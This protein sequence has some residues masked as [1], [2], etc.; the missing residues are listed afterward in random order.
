MIPDEELIEFI[1]I[2]RTRHKDYYDRIERRSDVSLANAPTAKNSIG[3]NI[4]ASDVGY[5]ST[6]QIG[7]PPRNFSVIM[8]SGSSDLWVGGEGCHTEVNGT[9]TGKNCGDK[10]VLEGPTSSSSFVD[11][12][13]P[14]NVTYGTGFVSG[15]IVTDNVVVAGLSLDRHTFGTALLESTEF[16]ADSV[17]TDGLMGLA[18][19][20]ASNQG[21]P[22]PP[23]AMA[24]K[25]LIKEAIV[26]YK[27]SRF[28]DGKGDGEITFGGLDDTKFNAATLVT[29]DNISKTGFW[30]A[31]V[32][33]VAV[34]GKDIGLT[35]RSAILDTGTT[36]VL[37]PA[38]DAQKIHD[39]IP[40][41]KSDGMGGY[42]LPCTANVTVSL[43]FGG[44]VFNIDPRDLVTSPVNADDPKGACVS[45]IVA[46][47]D[48]ASGNGPTQWLL[49]DVFLKDT[50]FSTNV[51]KMSISLARLV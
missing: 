12:N 4:E 28:S 34:D 6:I 15:N 25:G 18:L 26:S 7:T 2:R 11:T 41:A 1:I 48:A 39:A 20:T 44:G 8:D 14:F 37:A 42:T 21:A 5:Y 31:K 35:G 43:T 19:G 22:T 45:G 36:L 46:D 30:E 38:A 10:H 49:G 51:D 27:I 17:P 50:Y 16:S 9:A 23:E 13:K 32:D 33:V 29:V 24:K 3:L 47:T 40:G